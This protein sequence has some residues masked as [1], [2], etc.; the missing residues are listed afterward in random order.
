M[1]DLQEF[2]HL[3]DIETKQLSCKEIGL[4]MGT[5]YPHLIC[6]TESITGAADQPIG[7]KTPLGWVVIGP[8]RHQKADEKSEFVGTRVMYTTV[9]TSC[10]QES[11][12]FEDF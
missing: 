8:K 2:D 1:A 7:L 3:K 6:P 4:I 5:D 12:G 11:F 9:E 10:K